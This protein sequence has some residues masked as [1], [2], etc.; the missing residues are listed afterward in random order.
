MSSIFLITHVF[1]LVKLLIFKENN[2]IQ[3][4]E[5]AIFL[6]QCYL[7]MSSF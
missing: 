7:F 1:D 3:Q 4:N 5:N 2:N 6:L